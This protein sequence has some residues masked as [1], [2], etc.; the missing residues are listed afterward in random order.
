MSKSNLLEKKCQNQGYTRNAPG[1]SFYTKLAGKIMNC[2]L[3]G[4]GF[5][6]HQQD[7]LIKK[8]KQK[9]GTIY[10]KVLYREK[11]KKP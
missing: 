11:S 8:I 5:F 3:F 1:S 4:S 2:Y 7:T 9:N 10:M 6:Q